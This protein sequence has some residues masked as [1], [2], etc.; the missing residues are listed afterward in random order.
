M[1]LAVNRQDAVALRFGREQI[2]VVEYVYRAVARNYGI[3]RTAVDPRLLLHASTN[4]Q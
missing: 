3:L 1:I 4:T 2:C